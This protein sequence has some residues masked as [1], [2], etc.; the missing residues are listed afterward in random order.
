[1]AAAGAD[2]T[3]IHALAV[4]TPFAIGRVN[5]YLVED[6]P[7]TL[8]DAG[9]NSATSL[10]ALER[11]LAEHGRRV[12]DLE[13]VVLTH[14]HMDHVGLAGILAS[15][16]GAE[17]V[18]LDLLAPYLAD[19]DASMEADD[20][21]AE[22]VMARHGVPDEVAVALRA[23]SALARGWGA[24]VAVTRTLVDG[25]ELGFAGRTWR[26]HRRPGHSP[27]DTVF[28]D[29]RSGELIVGDHLLPRISSNPVAARPPD[30][31]IDAPRPHSLRMYVDSMTL[32]RDMEVTT[33]HPGHGESFAGH[34]TLIDDRLRMHERR[35]DKL[36]RL[37]SEQ[38]R[39]AHELAQEMWGSV[40]IAQ[41][42]L[43]LSEVLG[44]TDLL[45]EQGRVREEETDGVVRFFATG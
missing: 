7:L 22:R 8:V 45:V 30:G 27:T 5:C 16:S 26:A 19:W 38:P 10:V 41:A 43:T 34:A 28:H 37:I 25:D 9:P 18:A 11:M 44:H 29:E 15:R 42:Y 2:R 36:H 6:D 39:S 13:R 1:M 33:V 24:S 31:P 21:F 17:V 32:T 40:A 35:A 3:G 14:Q 12:E 4:P 20:R 23:V